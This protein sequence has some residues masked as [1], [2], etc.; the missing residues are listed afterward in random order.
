MQPR[1]AAPLWDRQRE[2]DAY[3]YVLV[4]EAHLFNENERRVL[5]YLTRGV[6]KYLPI[7]MT[8]DEVQSIGGK[9]PVELERVGIRNSS[10][11]TL[12]YVHRSSPDIFML[13]RD[14]VERSALVFSEFATGEAV[15]RMSERD[16]KK[17]QKPQ[18]VYCEED[19]VA[20]SVAKIA[21]NLR[22]KNYPRVGIV[23]FDI[24]LL[25]KIGAKAYSSIHVV[26]ERGELIAAV[27]T[28]GI[29]LMAPENCGGLEFDAVIL[30]GV[31]EGQLPPSFR[32]LSPE[33]HLSVREEAF[34]ELYT[35]ITRARYCVYFVCGEQR[36]LSSL[37][38]PSL[39][40]GYIVQQ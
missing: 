8:F 19:D 29:Y 10:L 40:A 23:A 37:I 24:G 35:A 6:H 11:R 32:D 13:A 14:L 33:G 18:L 16:L 20:E 28:P 12:T 7:V 4:D 22:S 30:A 3:D 25:F 36:G 1:L 15:P 31:D 5:P 38:K 21:M 17:C 26:K 9:R 27:P 39:N 2:A 34:K